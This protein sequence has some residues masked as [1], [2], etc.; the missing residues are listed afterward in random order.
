MEVSYADKVTMLDDNKTV[1]SSVESKVSIVPPPMIN[2][3]I[4][5]SRILEDPSKVAILLSLEPSTFEV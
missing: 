4:L 3:Q 1:I 5:D 2:V